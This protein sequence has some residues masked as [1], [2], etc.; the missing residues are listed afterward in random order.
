MNKAGNFV[1]GAIIGAALG[2]LAGYVFAPAQDADFERNYRSR[3]DEALEEGRKASVQ[4]EAELRRQF[5]AAK[6]PRSDQSPG[7]EGLPSAP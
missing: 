1:F 3:L 2:L 6:Q 4:R 7:S 5:A